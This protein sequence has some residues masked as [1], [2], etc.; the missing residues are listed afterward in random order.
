MEKYIVDYL[1]HLDYLRHFDLPYNVG[2]LLSLLAS[3]FI[4]FPFSF[5][6]KSQVSY[7]WEQKLRPQ[8]QPLTN[9]VILKM[10]YVLK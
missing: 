10:S 2:R 5:P 1:M 6:S 4:T 9:S 3:H 7:G 8:T